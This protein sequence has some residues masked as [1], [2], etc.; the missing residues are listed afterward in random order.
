LSVIKVS[1]FKSGAE[2]GFRNISRFAHEVANIENNEKNNMMCA[3]LNFK[4]L[5]RLHPKI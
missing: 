2:A 3:N 4:A 1:K 5:A